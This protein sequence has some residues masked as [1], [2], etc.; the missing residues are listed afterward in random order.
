M[1]TLK[2]ECRSRSDKRVT[3]SE[4]K[5]LGC[6]GCL[7]AKCQSCG[8]SLMDTTCLRG[9]CT[10][11]TGSPSQ[12]ITSITVHYRGGCAMQAA[13]HWEGGSQVLWQTRIH[14]YCNLIM[15]SEMRQRTDTQHVPVWAAESADGALKVSLWRAHSFVVGHTLGLQ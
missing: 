3:E 10:R 2:P 14:G 9:N 13:G 6:L 4:S 1:K 5:S 12:P 11:P 15:C 7:P 8:K